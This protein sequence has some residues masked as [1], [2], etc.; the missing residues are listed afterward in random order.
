MIPF[1]LNKDKAMLSVGTGLRGVNKGVG[2][3]EIGIGIYD[4]GAVGGLAG[5]NNNMSIFQTE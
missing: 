3:G 1:G 5:D 4:W 2:V